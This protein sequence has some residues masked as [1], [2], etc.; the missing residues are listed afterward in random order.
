[1]KSVEPQS[2]NKKVS[3]LNKWLVYRFDEVIVQAPPFAEEMQGLVE[4]FMIDET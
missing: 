2:I 3:Y 1:M 4:Q